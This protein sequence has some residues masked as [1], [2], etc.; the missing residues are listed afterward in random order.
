MLASWDRPFFYISNLNA[1]PSSYGPVASVNINAGWSVDYASSTPSFIAGLIDNGVAVYST[2]GGQ[3]WTKL[4]KRAAH[5]PVRPM[6]G[7]L[8]PARRKTSSLRQA[9]VFNPIIPSTAA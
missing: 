6:E 1:Y 7:R 2:N 4:C 9:M 8:P 3:T 5:S